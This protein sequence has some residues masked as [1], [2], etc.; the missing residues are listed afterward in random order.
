MLQDYNERVI[1]LVDV[2][3]D[4]SKIPVK[5]LTETSSKK[6]DAVNARCVIAVILR[7][8]GYTFDSIANLLGVDV[9]NAHTY[10]M[11]HDNRM[12]DSNYSRLY[13]DVSRVHEG[14]SDSDEDVRKQ[15]TDLRVRFEKIE[16]RVIHL[17]DL[18]LGND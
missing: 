6:K 13:K 15:L 18:I 2:V 1:R 4:F 11:S 17:T 3:S 12:A 9:K 14:A 7:N 10:V 16:R 5:D 8:D